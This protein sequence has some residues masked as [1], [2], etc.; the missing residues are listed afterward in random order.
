M[1]SV[2][3]NNEGELF[4]DRFEKLVPVLCPHGTNFKK[5]NLH[6]ALFSVDYHTK[7]GSNFHVDIEYIHI[8]L[9]HNVEHIY[10]KRDFDNKF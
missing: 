1:T 5:C 3:I 8:K 9:C 2:A 6:C 7:F 4:L 10:D